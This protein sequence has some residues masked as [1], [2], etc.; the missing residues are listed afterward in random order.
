MKDVIA[1][2]SQLPLTQRSSEG[3]SS[4]VPDESLEIS[5]SSILAS[6]RSSS[7]KKTSKNQEKPRF[8]EFVI[9]HFQVANFIRTCLGKILPGDA[10]GSQGNLRQLLDGKQA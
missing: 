7:F 6:S 2:D 1:E 9:P 5:R 4:L 3:A 8:A 10:L